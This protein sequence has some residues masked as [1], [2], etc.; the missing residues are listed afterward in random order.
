MADRIDDDVFVTDQS[1]KVIRLPEMSDNRPG[2]VSSE[3]EYMMKSFTTSFHH[4]KTMLADKLDRGEV[5]VTDD[6]VIPPTFTYLPSTEVITF[7]INR[8]TK[9]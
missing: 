7:M 5:H 1:G 9:A 6:M 4:S 3:K 8:A 2:S